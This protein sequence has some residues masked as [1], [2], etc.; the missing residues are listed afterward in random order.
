MSTPYKGA[1]PQSCTP[2]KAPP[3][4]PQTS[5]KV[6]HNPPNQMLSTNNNEEPH[7][8][9]VLHA[10]HHSSFFKCLTI[11]YK[12]CNRSNRVPVLPFQEESSGH[13]FWRFFSFK[14]KHSISKTLGDK[15]QTDKWCWRGLSV[16]RTEMTRKVK[17]FL[18][19]KF[20]LKIYHS[21]KP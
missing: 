15:R 1:T 4:H 7:P 11:N 2:C 9:A 6:K 3:R 21:C 17:R 8:R 12:V 20:L 18:N 19:L 14:S 10:R 16:L 13:Y 5:L